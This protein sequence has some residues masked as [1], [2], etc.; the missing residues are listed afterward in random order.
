MKIKKT[1]Q[2]IV[3]QIRDN[4]TCNASK[5]IKSPTWGFVWN[6]I[7]SNVDYEVEL[8]EMVYDLIIKKAHEV[9]NC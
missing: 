8:F 6:K 9:K 4:V 3:D 2:Q 7:R 1:E 5:E